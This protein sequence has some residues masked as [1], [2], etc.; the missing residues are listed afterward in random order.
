MYVLF[1]YLPMLLVSLSSG[2]KKLRFILMCKPPRDLAHQNRKRYCIVK[3]YVP[4][5]GCA[6][7]VCFC[8][9]VFLCSK[10]RLW[11]PSCQC[12]QPTDTFFFG[13]F[14]SHRFVVCRFCTSRQYF[15]YS[16]MK[17]QFYFLYPK[18]NPLRWIYF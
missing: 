6:G 13:C 1:V 8:V 14:F 16:A 15:G 12:L 3:G 17:N 10:N 4:F 2:G 5:F 9:F 11:T 18:I 7:K